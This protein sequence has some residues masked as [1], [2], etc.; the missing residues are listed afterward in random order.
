MGKIVG[1]EP[2]PKCRAEGGDK[3]G[4]H[5]IIFDDGGRSCKKHGYLGKEGEDMTDKKDSRT[6]IAMVKTLPVKAAADRGIRKDTMMRYR[7]RTGCNEENG[8][9][10][11][12][13]YPYTKDG[14]LLS[15]KVRKFPKQFSV[16]GG[17]KDVELFGQ[18]LFKPGSNKRVLLTGGEM[19]AMA[20]YQML[21]DYSD[22]KYPGRG[23]EPVVVSMP[24]GESTNG[25]QSNFKWLDSFEEIIICMDSD[26]AGQ[27]AANDICSMLARAGVF[28]IDLPYKDPND[29]LVANKEGQFIS[30]Y[31][32][33]EEWKPDEFSGIDYEELLVPDE[34]GFSTPYP[35]LDHK[36]HGLR[37]GE[38]VMLTAGSGIGKSTLARELAVNLMI[39]H[40]QKV[41]CF[42]LEES[43]RTTLRTFIAIKNSISPL[44]MRI[45][46]DQIDEAILRD[47]Y[48]FFK[49]RAV[50]Y[51][52]P[53]QGIQ[54]DDQLIAA[55]RYMVKVQGCTFIVLD[56][57]SIIL[58]NRSASREG[59]RKD[60]DRLMTTL[61]A[62]VVEYNVGILSISHLTRN[63]DKN[64]NG[65]GVPDL[66][67]LRGSGALE[68]LSW[69]VIAMSRDQSG[70][71]PN[72][73]DISVLK[74]RPWGFVGKADSVMYQH[75]TGRLLPVATEEE[76]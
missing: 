19:D 63:R 18:H 28:K 39:K 38:L 71:L 35:E 21:K 73:A 26:D 14:K 64:W 16:I 55:L 68:Q 27:K 32:N 57:I 37:R 47:G 11:A 10:S 41:G 15:Y 2:C 33:A 3:T 29:M 70:D 40:E 13:Y 66:Q 65:G 51:D 44:D 12:H 43:L 6:T 60:I 4:N 62:F 7:V 72:R 53:P 74:N 76:Y 49:E 25:I 1:D 36:I 23:Y 24:N 22:K 54:S 34:I 48:D 61:A 56:H 42:F 17:M 59:E 50:M 20:A 9:D 75:E 8:E 67:D 52:K 5:A 30:C 45:H 46:P 58:S 31:Y 69:I